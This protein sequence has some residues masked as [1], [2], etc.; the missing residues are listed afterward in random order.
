MACGASALRST[1]VL[2]TSTGLPLQPVD[3]LG[4]LEVFGAAELGQRLGRL[5]RALGRFFLEPLARFLARLGARL[6]L[7]LGALAAFEVLVEI[8]LA[9]AQRG[10]QV[11]LGGLVEH[12]VGDD[13]AAPGSTCRSACSSARW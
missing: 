6:V 13:A 8:G 2:L 9:R 3:R 11:A 5:G 10:E 4:E 7:H 1:A 12:H